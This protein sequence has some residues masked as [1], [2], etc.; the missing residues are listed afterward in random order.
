MT[1]EQDPEGSSVRAETGSKLE[2]PNRGTKA[3]LYA[4]FMQLIGLF[5]FII[6]SIITAVFLFFVFTR[7]VDE[8][9]FSALRS[10][11]LLITLSAVSLIIALI[12]RSQNAFV[13]SFGI[14]LIGAL[15]VPSSDL[16]KFALIASGSQ[17]QIS[18]GVLFVCHG[19]L[20]SG[21][22]YRANRCL[23][24]LYT[25]GGRRVASPL[26]FASICKKYMPA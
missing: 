16:V 6:F 14:F 26:A 23:R 22:R 17:S 3:F 2:P 1:T 24:K 13:L 11:E 12:G 4:E 9:N 19:S 5:G 15:I 8:V 20:L 25:G 18:Q 21:S 7:T 10:A